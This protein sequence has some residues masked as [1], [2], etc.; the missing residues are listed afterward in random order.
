VLER[1]FFH[2]QYRVASLKLRPDLH[3]VPGDRLPRLAWRLT[4]AAIQ[5]PDK[6]MLR[7][8]VAV[9]GWLVVLAPAGAARRFVGMR[10]IGQR[11]PVALDR[12][13]H[14]LGLVRR[15]APRPSPLVAGE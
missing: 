7:V 3:P 8:L 9:W 4:R 2:L 10:F 14:R 13:L 6:P 5:A 1:A 12:F 15:T 11:R